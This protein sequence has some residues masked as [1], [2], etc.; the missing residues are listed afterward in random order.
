MGDRCN[1]VAVNGIAGEDYISGSSMSE[2]F[3]I[4]LH[5]NSK[6]CTGLLDTGATHTI[7]IRGIAQPTRLSV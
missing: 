6:P 3:T 4:S 5:V 7:L 1:A 2:L